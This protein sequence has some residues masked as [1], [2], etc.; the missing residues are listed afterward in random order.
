[1]TFWRRHDT[2]TEHTHWGSCPLLFFLP[3]MVVYHILL[4]HL[5]FS[6]RGHTI[7][8]HKW[9][10]FSLMATQ[11][12]IICLLTIPLLVTSRLFIVYLVP[13]FEQKAFVLEEL[14]ILGFNCQVRLKSKDEESLSHPDR[15]TPHTVEMKTFPGYLQCK[16]QLNLEI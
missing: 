12:F 2:Q 3:E 10:L 8:M 7:A 1:M 14:T 4:S 13:Q 5:A 15:L 9:S 11:Y 6:L 16:L